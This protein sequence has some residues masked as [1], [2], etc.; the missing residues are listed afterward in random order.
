M[1]VQQVG[2]AVEFA[3]LQSI[4]EPSSRHKCRLRTCA[5]D[6]R[7]DRYRTLMREMLYLIDINAHSTRYVFETTPDT[8][9]QVV[10]RWCL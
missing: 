3:N 8:G 10:G 4:T 6:E 2:R 5:L 9:A 1:V 7:V